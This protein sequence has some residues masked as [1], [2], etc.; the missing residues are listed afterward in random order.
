MLGEPLTTYKVEIANSCVTDI[1]NDALTHL[2][3][4]SV[5]G[6]DELFSHNSW[7]KQR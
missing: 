2:L 3:A 7:L 1:F 4:L 5:F 6:E